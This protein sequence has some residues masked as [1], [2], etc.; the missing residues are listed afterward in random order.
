MAMQICN[1]CSQ[2]KSLDMFHMKRTIASGYR[3]IC[4]ECRKIELRVYNFLPKNVEKRKGAWSRM[5]EDAKAKAKVL[6]KKNHLRRKF[7]ITFE[8]FEEMQIRQNH[9]CSICSD[10]LSSDS[11]YVHIDHCHKTGSIR[12]ILCQKCNAALGMVRDNIDIL[13]KAIIYLKKHGITK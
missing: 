8:Q 9:S 11:R 5:S 13:E 12:E 10:K 1:K 6:H 7:G 3:K 2:E 4:K